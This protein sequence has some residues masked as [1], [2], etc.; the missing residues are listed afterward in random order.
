MEVLGR[1]F[2]RFVDAQTKKNT[3]YTRENRAH[4]VLQ[5]GVFFARSGQ[6]LFVQ[7]LVRQ[8]IHNKGLFFF[9]QSPISYHIMPAVCGT[10]VTHPRG[11]QHREGLYVTVSS[12]VV[13]TQQARQH[14]DPSN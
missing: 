14:R 8:G 13:P 7:P 2:G 4:L 9:F 10:A 1:C 5:E 3:S 11:K 6:L 12:T